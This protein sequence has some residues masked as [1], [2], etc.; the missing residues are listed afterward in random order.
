MA[1]LNVSGKAGFNAGETFSKLVRISDIKID[2]EISKIFTRSDKIRDEIKTKIEK[3]GFD[4]S[5]PVTLWKGKNI[6]VDGHT[7]L[8]AA[9][10]NNLEKIPAVELEFETH[11]DAILYTFERQ[12]IRRNLTPADILKAAQLMKGPKTRDGT[13]RKADLLA[14]RLGVCAATIYQARKIAKEASKEDITAIQKGETSLKAVYKKL[15]KPNDSIFTVTDAQ[16]LPENVKF[17][18]GAVILLAEARESTALKLLINHFLK[19]HEKNGFY[20]LLPEPLQQEVQNPGGGPKQASFD[21]VA[22]ALGQLQLLTEYLKALESN[23]PRQILKTACT[24]LKEAQTCLK[25]PLSL[26][27]SQNDLSNRIIPPHDEPH[28]SQSNN[29]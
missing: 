26:K 14:E 25:A 18:K 23:V 20:R 24:Y 4:K 10:E 3:F 13:G 11:D 6:I 9:I 22:H 19:K 1:K 12:A 29:A 5:Q 21:L 2:P 27:P 8:E 15:T 7:R 28:L 16:N 17:L